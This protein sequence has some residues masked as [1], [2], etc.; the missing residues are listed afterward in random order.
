VVD[1]WQLLITINPTAPAE[2]YFPR[3]GFIDQMKALLPPAE[4]VVAQGESFPANSGLIYN[5]RDW[6]A[7]D[8]MISEWAFKA[9]HYLSPDYS[10]GIWT[11]Y[12][13]FFP[14]VNLPV[15]PALGIR[16]FISE[17]TNL[18]NT[19]DPDPD[20]PNIKR[21]AYKDGLGLYEI[22]G[23]PGFTYLSDYLWVEPDEEGADHW[24]QRVT[25]AKMRAYGAVVEAPERKVESIQ[26]APDGS[27]PGSSTVREYTPGHIVLDVE[28]KRPAL[29]VVAESYY[30]GWKATIDGEPAEVLRANF[31][32]QGLVVTEGKH[33]V[34]FRYDPDSVRYGTLLS[35]V[36]VLGLLGIIW[37]A[38]PWRRR[39]HKA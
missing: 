37:W 18:N 31:L 38:G 33:A 6:R 13:M 32:S 3:T 28:A 34:V 26:R 36:G 1:L 4:R 21:L 23:V 2:Y 29:L 25:W 17:S 12:N 15:A 7:Q 20:R 30:P 35:G 24:L 39:V 14:T 11:E 19:D 16:Y 22:E 8:P 10:K 27:S 9:A 5:I